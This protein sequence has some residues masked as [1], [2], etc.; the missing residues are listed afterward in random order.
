M[1]R[2]LTLTGN[3][4][5]PPATMQ[6]KKREMDFDVVR[7]IGLALPGVEESTLH[8][9]PSLK[10]SGRLLTCPA[11]HKSAEPDSLAVR[12][13]FEQ[14]Q[15]LLA[16]HPRVYYV[17]DHYINHPVVLVRLSRIGRASLR[18]LLGRAWQFVNAKAK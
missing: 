13:S 18:K 16:A 2:P 8:G 4:P 15:E 10:L 1:T 12:I 14:R 6:R 7:E 3:R 9:A 5:A 11:I 17:T